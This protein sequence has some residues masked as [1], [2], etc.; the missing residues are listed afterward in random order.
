VAV[1]ADPVFEADDPRVGSH[2]TSN[3][4]KNM[5]HAVA[6]MRGGQ[7]SGS[8]HYFPRLLASREEA[9][10]IMRI[11][12][13]Q[14][15]LTAL[16]FEASRGLVSSPQLAQYRIVHFA[17]HAEI[18]SQDPEQSRIVLSRF[19]ADG[20]PE[21]GFLRMSDIYELH[22]PAD[23]V[24][25]SA[26]QTG[27]GKDVRGEGLIGLTRAFMYA[28]ASGVTASLWKVDDEATA[29]LMKR[30]YQGMFRDD[31]PPAAAL[32]QAQIAMWQQSRWHAPYYWAAFVIQGRYDQKEEMS[33]RAVQWSVISAG[34]LSVCFLLACTL[35]PRRRSTNV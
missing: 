34:L 12:P 4:G 5:K 31:L 2:T 3:S 33:S 13:W 10:A 11:I 35:L 23:L 9:E 19:K 24:V 21:D 1:I 8:G 28:G 29:E 15:G 18:D 25:L 14:T 22:L 27:L 26:C 6:F 20:Q 30:F 16:D 17:T 32:R 7:D